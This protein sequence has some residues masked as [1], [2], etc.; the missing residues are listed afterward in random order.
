MIWWPRTRCAHVRA[1]ASAF[2]DGRLAASRRAVV[3]EHLHTC[4]ACLSELQQFAR[5]SRAMHNLPPFRL[6]DGMASRLRRQLA[7]APRP[8]APPRVARRAAAFAALA[9]AAAVFAAGYLCGRRDA[10]HPAAPAPHQLPPPDATASS[11]VQLPGRIAPTPLP[12]PAPSRA[13]AAQR[14]AGSPPPANAR[15]ASCDDD[16]PPAPL[17]RRRTPDA[18]ELLDELL[19]QMSGEQPGP[20]PRR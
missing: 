17:L 4:T 2:L 12:A 16:A 8:A 15:W 11:P 3:Q 1:C 9:A 19:R 13:P 20:P 14:A 6:A 10:G 5:L 7:A 18:A